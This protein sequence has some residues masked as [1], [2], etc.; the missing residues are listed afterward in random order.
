MSD[1]DTYVKLA[2]ILWPIAAWV[3]WVNVTVKRTEKDLDHLYFVMRGKQGRRN[4][5]LPAKLKRTS[6]QIRKKI[7]GK[8]SSKDAHKTS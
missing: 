8:F 5:S 6:Y 2:K 1:L 4:R 7:R 3:G